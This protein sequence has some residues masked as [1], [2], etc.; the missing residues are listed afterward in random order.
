M[1]VVTIACAHCGAPIER[2]KELENGTRFHVWMDLPCQN[3]GY[4]TSIIPGVEYRR[5][6]VAR[7]ARCECDRVFSSGGTD[8]LYCTRCG[9]RLP[10]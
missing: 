6:Y 9:W 3:C 8:E 2:T 7:C 1:S 10:E 5:P 4:K